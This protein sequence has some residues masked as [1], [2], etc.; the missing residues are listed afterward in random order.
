MV[1]KNRPKTRWNL[2]P[3]VTDFDAAGAD[4]FA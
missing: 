3:V 2:V 4:A 1:T